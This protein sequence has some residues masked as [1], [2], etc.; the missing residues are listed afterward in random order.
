MLKEKL[1]EDLKKRKKNKN[2]VRKNVI[3]RECI[4]WCVN[5]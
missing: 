1:L 3:Q 5:Y 4:I 2:V